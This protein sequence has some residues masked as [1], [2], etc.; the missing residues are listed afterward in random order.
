M[1]GT[2]SSFDRKK[3]ELEAVLSPADIEAMRKVKLLMLDVDGVL[4]DGRLFYDSE[5]RESKVFHVQDG[6]GLVYWKRSGFV[7]GLLSGRE[8]KC[9]RVRAKELRVDEVHLGK[10]H[11]LPV[12]QEVLERRNLSLE[13]VCY[14]GDDFL[15]LEVL[16]CVGMPVSVPQGRPEVKAVCRYITQAPAGFGAVRELVELLL[17]AKGLFQSIVDASGKPRGVK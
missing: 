17:E 3:V 15:D 7:S 14:V 2:D 16:R 12:L 1:H 5:G 8:A 10:G 13:E 11:K 4:T 6:A 9:I